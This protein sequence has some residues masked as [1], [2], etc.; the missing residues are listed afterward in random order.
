VLLTL[1]KRGRFFIKIQTKMLT[2]FFLF[3]KERGRGR[4]LPAQVYCEAEDLRERLKIKDR[5]AR[6]E[7]INEVKLQDKNLTLIFDAGHSAAFL[8]P[9]CGMSALAERTYHCSPLPED[10]SGAR[11]LELITCNQC[12][13]AQIN[14]YGESWRNALNGVKRTSR[15]LEKRREMEEELEKLRARNLELS[16]ALEKIKSHQHGKIFDKVLN[17]LKNPVAMV[18]VFAVIA[19]FVFA[20]VISEQMGNLKI[21]LLG[22]EFSLM[23]CQQETARDKSSAPKI[24][25]GTQSFSKKI[26]RLKEAALNEIKNK[27]R[28]LD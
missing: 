8:C 10:E 11:Q 22:S 17:F 12:A 4:K 23:S 18:G 2:K 6:G 9:E 3:E 19:L 24:K 20:N 13:Y 25:V 5:F 28:K 15:V 1:E 7:K 14:V 16:T 27:V 21:S 26:P